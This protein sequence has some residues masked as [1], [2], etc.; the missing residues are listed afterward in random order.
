MFKS[1][2]FWSLG[3]GQ[4]RLVP[5]LLILSNVSKRM[6]SMRVSYTIDT[7][8]TLL[9]TATISYQLAMNDLYTPHKVTFL[10]PG[11]TVSYAVLRP[12]SKKA[13]STIEPGQNLPVHLNLHGA[14]LESDSDQVRHMLDQLP[15][16]RAFVL[17]PTGVTPWS[18]DDWHDWGF[19]DVQAAVAS[20]PKWV[21]QVGWHGPPANIDKWFVSGHSNGG[22]GTLYALTHYP[23]KIVG[24][25]P[26]SGYTSIQ[27]YVPFHMWNEADSRVTHVVESSLQSFRHEL[28]VKNFKGIPVLEQHGD[29]DD[30]VPTFHS[31]RLYQLTS[32]A[33][34]TKSR[35]YAEL[36]GKGHWYDGV[37][38]TPT[39]RAFYSH[40]LANEARMPDLPQVFEIVVANPADMGSRGG[41][42]VD[43]LTSPDQLGKLHVSWNVASNSVHCETSNVRRFHFTTA[44]P[45]IKESSKLVVD[46][47]TFPNLEHITSILDGDSVVWWLLFENGSWKVSRVSV[48]YG[49]AD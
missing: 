32:Q 23:D 22:Q 47:H 31:R 42:Q 48:C 25:A 19:A 33:G 39:L 40:C 20:I 49:G 35:E 6:V 3:P 7:K 5:F 12:P 24:A 26:V 18:G 46:G 11:R 43:Q 14:G 9:Y 45:L 44:S 16:L 29:E 41:L 30:N 34:Q 36:T 37:M 8:S 21:Q 17:F 4:T 10:H 38:T 1:P 28:L 2:P 15:D 27:Q 13:I